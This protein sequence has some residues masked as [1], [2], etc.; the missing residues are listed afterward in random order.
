VQSEPDRFGAVVLGAPMLDFLANVRGSSLLRVPLLGEL[1]THGYIVPML[2]RRRARRYRD[3]EDGRFVGKFMDQVAYPG[4]GRAMLSLMTSGAL[5]NQSDVYAALG[6]LRNPVCLLRGSDDNI[7]TAS[8]FDAI[9]RLMPKARRSTLDGTA[10]AMILT[11]PERV[12]TEV[13]RFFDGHDVSAAPTVDSAGSP[14]TTHRAK[15]SP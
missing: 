5:G 7:V 12:A 6:R 2:K 14:G 11:H 15:T 10:H 4:F 9:G 8:Q 1:L 3:I 13:I